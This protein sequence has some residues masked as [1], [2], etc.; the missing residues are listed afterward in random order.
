VKLAS[1]MCVATLLL[2]GCP[3]SQLNDLKKDEGANNYTAIENT[4][5]D[6]TCAGKGQGSAECAQASEI[7]G[8]A[9]MTLARQEA[10]ANAACPPD[11]AAAQRALKCAA[12][13]LDASR[14]GQQFPSDQLIE[15][16]EM[17]ARALY[18][19]ATLKS[20]SDGLPDAREAARELESPS[21]PASA[22]REQLAAA[23]ELYVANSDQLPN[24][25]RCSAALRAIARADRGLQESPDDNMTQGLQ[26]TREHAASVAAHLTGC[27]TS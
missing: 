6:S 27:P 26:A 19:G 25:E 5:I 18:C 17:H 15:L 21:L 3:L 22:Q 12:T 1:S 8:R 9:C 20:R 24:A 2:A 7:Q 23:S 13:D 11:T 16:G 14:L 4:S 10:A